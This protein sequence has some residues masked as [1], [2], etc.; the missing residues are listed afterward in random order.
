MKKRKIILIIGMIM[1]ACWLWP[2]SAF[3]NN[4]TVSNVSLYKVPGQPAGTIAV[5]FDLTWDNSFTSMDSNGNAF[6]DRAW[7][8]IKY[9]NNAWE[10][11]SAWAHGSLI[12]GGSVG[13]YNSATGVGIAANSDSG[14]K[15]GAFCKPGK[16]Q[17]IFWNYGGAGGD[18]ILDTAEVLV[19]VMAVEMVY[20]PQG[21]FYLGSGA[22]GAWMEIGNFTDGSWIKGPTIPFKVA[23]ENT[24][25][26]NTGVGNLWGTAA[27][28]SSGVGPS[29]TLPATFP[30][31]Y[32]GFYMMKYEISVGQYRDF[33]N[34]LTRAQQNA[35][36]YTNIAAGVT[37]VT[38]HQYVMGDYSH[39]SKRNSIRCDTTIPA[40]GPITFYCDY[41]ENGVPDEANDGEWAPCTY[42]SWAESCAFAD[43]AGLR[44]MT[45]LEY[46]KVCRGPLYP[47][48]NEFAWGTTSIKNSYYEKTNLNT[49]S[50]GINDAFFSTTAGNCM[51]SVTIGGFDNAMRCGV[52]AANVNNTGRVTAGAGYYG[53][54]ELSGNLTERVVTLGRAEGRVFNGLHGDGDLAATPV[55]WPVA[56]LGAGLRGGSW[57]NTAPDLTVSNRSNGNTTAS[58][59]SGYY[60]IRFVRT[61]P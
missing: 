58:S 52:F 57:Y 12:S 19:K 61:A 43:W 28:D 7:V 32:Q 48:A 9:W 38:N 40:S 21:A 56:G 29:G 49:A 51:Y 25:T 24:I 17:T 41:N 11:D 31:G 47:V 13:D 15:V 54:M 30:K 22:I 34:T 33:L 39:P 2:Q 46:E 14:K 37:D 20:V 42:L 53:N 35:Y 4:L 55:N 1:L 23:S 44:P 16:N 18:G 59:R 3:A 5:K 26:I 50:E 60:S 10:A 6:F 45:E 36:T 27:S 8:F